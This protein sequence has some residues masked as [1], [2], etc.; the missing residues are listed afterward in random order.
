VVASVVQGA[1]NACSKLDCALIG[2]ETAELPGIYRENEFDLAGCMIGIASEAEL[3]DINRVESGDAVVALPSNGLH[4]NGYSLA[5]RVLS[6]YSLDHVFPELGRSLADELLAIHRPYV[7]DLRGLLPKVR[8][9][10]HIT[11]GG[12]FDNIPRVL[13][14]SLGVDLEW[15]TW[16]VPPIFELIRDIGNV[17]FDEMCHVFNM[18]IGMAVICAPENADAFVH[19]IPGASLAGIV[20]PLKTGAERVRILR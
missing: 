7:K 8:S 2:G 18:G 12:L 11:G 6:D 4:T 14:E 15:G 19:H 3:I 10:A 17:D 1:A 9:M 20:R 5:R 16:Q 13:P